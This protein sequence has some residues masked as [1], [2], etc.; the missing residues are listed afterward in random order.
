[1]AM[2]YQPS[3]RTMVLA[4]QVVEEMWYGLDPGTTT[5]ADMT[6]IMY[7]QHMELIRSG[8]EDE[9]PRGIGIKE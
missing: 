7:R 2:K 4:R 6:I 1:M 5:K 9:I 3:L 8:R